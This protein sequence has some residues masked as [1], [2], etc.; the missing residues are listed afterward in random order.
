VVRGGL[1]RPPSGPGWD[2]RRRTVDARVVH[3]RPQLSRDPLGGGL[4]KGVAP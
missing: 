3:A 2:R 4:D 1:G